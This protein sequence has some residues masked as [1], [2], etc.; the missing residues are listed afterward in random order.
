MLGSSIDSKSCGCVRMLRTSGLSLRPLAV[1]SVASCLQRRRRGRRGHELAPQLL[2]D[3]RAVAVL[4]EHE[5]DRRVGVVV[6]EL[7]EQRLRAVEPAAGVEQRLGVVR[8]L[9]VDVPAGERLRELRDVVLGV[10]LGARDRVRHAEREELHQLAAVVLVR[11]ALDV[12]L[13]V[14]VAQHRRVLGHLERHVAERDVRVR[15]EVGV[16][17][18]QRVLVDHQLRRRDLLA[19][20]GPVAVPEERHPLDQRIAGAAPCGRP[21]RARGRC[22]RPWGRAACR[23]FVGSGP[24]S[25]PCGVL[26]SE[27][28]AS[29]E[30]LADPGGAV[31][32]G[33]A[34]AGAP[35]QP[36]DHRLRH[37]RRREA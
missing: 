12:G 18:Q 34:E 1:Y 8:V 20:V 36:V 23:R 37:R 9:V 10:V 30:R 3:V 27:S 14:Q 25:A 33:G 15:G 13:A 35:E 21:T 6:A 28:T 16:L 32:R 31:G 7:A 26:S 11:A 29:V 22:R 17:A 24:T 2:D 5:V 19:R 4:V